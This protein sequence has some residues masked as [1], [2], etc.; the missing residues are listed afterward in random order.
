VLI[1]EWRRVR[2]A[3]EYWVSDDGFVRRGEHGAPLPQ[4]LS[5][6]YL[7]VDLWSDKRHLRRRVHRLVAEAFHGF[8]PPGREVNHID[9]DIYNNRAE[10]LEYLTRSENIR[11]AMAKRGSYCGERHSQAK[12]TEA[13]VRLIR[14]RWAAGADRRS[15]AAEFGVS[16]STIRR[17]LGLAKYRPWVLADEHRD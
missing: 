2:E 10:N 7:V 8:C 17:A 16:E 3:P 12:L 4:H 6:G 1:R 5:R 15:L 11:D 14:G 13:A 9:G